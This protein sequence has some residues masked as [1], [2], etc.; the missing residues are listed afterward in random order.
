VA[1][2]SQLAKL[3][4]DDGAAGDAFGWPV[5]IEGQIAIVGVPGD[6]DNGSISGSAY[7]FDVATGAQ[8]AKLLPADGAAQSMFGWSVA[9]DGQ[10]AIVGARDGGENGKYSGSAY[11]FDMATGEQLAKL[12]PDVGAAFDLFGWSVAISSSIAIVGSAWDDDNG[13]NSGSAYV[14]DLDCPSATP[15]D[16]NGDGIVDGSDLLILLSAWGECA[17]PDDCPAD[18]DGDGEVGASDLLT[19]LSNWG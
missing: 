15:G 11:L 18:L 14:F 19:L 16:L 6:D 7:L 4:P 8:L 5:A 9:T 12:L 13:T 1:T 3:L 2:G 10:K 17:D